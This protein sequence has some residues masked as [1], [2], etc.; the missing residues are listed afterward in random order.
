MKKIIPMILILSILFSVLVSCNMKKDPNSTDS[1]S[2]SQT[3][4][5]VETE[6]KT[7]DILG[8]D[9]EDNNYNDF[10]ILQ[11]T[12]YSNDFYAEKNSG[13]LVNDA[14]YERNLSC[15]EYLGITISYIL[16]PGNWNSDMSQKIYN[17]VLSGTYAWDMVSMSLNGGILGGYVDCYM[18]VLE[19]DYINTEHSWWVQEMKEMV[20]VNDKMIFLTGDC[21]M[22]TYSC[23]GCVFANLDVAEQYGLNVDFYNLVS[24]G[25]WTLEKFISSYKGVLSDINGDGIDYNTDTFGWANYGI[26]VRVLWSS[27]D[28]NLLEQGSDG[29]YTV[30]PTLEERVINFANQLMGAYKEPNSVYFQTNEQDVVSAFT[31]DRCL[32]VTHLL[33]MAEKFNQNNMESKYAILPMPKYDSEQKDYITANQSSYNVLFFPKTIA[34]PE[35]SAKVAEYMGWYGQ[36]NVVP[37]YYDVTL[38][39]RYNNVEKNVEML[40]LIRENLRVTSNEVYG[41]VGDMI[42]LTAMTAKNTADTGFYSNPAS[43]W[44]SKY[45][46]YNEK[47]TAYINN[48]FK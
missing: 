36:K 37:A 23:M 30:K 38:K 2:D 5:T 35:L 12:I 3:T 27:C 47:L 18:N 25:E 45:S 22:S 11:N 16:E 41:V 17:T 15:E 13:S 32:F 29:T 21:S 43:V 19:M 39:Y 44:K 42:G 48:Y 10:I 33:Y 20:A 46:A 24:N 6:M 4:A 8:F 26:G 1:S 9:T 14:V 40:D 28:M 31:N 34:S 7:S